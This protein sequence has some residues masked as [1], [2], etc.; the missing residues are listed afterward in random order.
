VLSG[1]REGE[2]S[3]PLAGCRCRVGRLGEK[4]SRGRLSSPRPRRGVRV[5]EVQGRP[6]GGE[7]GRLGRIVQDVQDR[8]CRVGRLGEREGEGRATRSSRVVQRP[9]GAG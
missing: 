7:G 8:E 2:A 5:G 9:R 4:G 1:G 3:A 6:A